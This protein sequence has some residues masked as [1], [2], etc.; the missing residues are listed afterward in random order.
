MRDRVPRATPPPPALTRR[1]AMATLAAA[2]AS[3]LPS[4]RRI[5]P[6]PAPITADQAGELYVRLSLSLARHQPSLVDTWLGAAA[7]GDAPASRSR[8]SRRASPTRARRWRSWRRR[9]M[10]PNSCAVAISPDSCT[11]SPW[12][13]V[14]SPAS[15]AS[16][17][18]EAAEAFGVRPP[19]RDVAAMDRV[20]QE[21]S[22]RL[23]GRGHRW[24]SV[25]P[26]SGDAWRCHPIA[27]SACSPTRSAGAAKR[28]GRC[29]RPTGRAGGAAR[30]RRARVGGVLPP[31]R[32]AHLGPV[33]VA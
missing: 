28:R 13:P 17:A 20:R 18:D 12:R 26:R 14:A 6:G 24:P 32:R 29:C 22:E 1:Q 8:R 31:A 9:P 5:P 30:L 21:L 19:P 4:C 2:G 33:G 3:L 27:W 23:P 16:F 25:T 15:S 7:W 10:T 11:P